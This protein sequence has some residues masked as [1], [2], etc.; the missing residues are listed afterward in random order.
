MFGKRLRAMRIKRNFTQPQLADMLN[1][2]LRTY[3]GYEGGT[4]SPSFSTLIKI[5]DI[6]DVSLD[7]LL[8]RD[9]FMKAHAIS[10]DEYL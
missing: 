5:A 7:Y 9:D 2:A 1:V 6:L 8:G 10:A 4:R 3:Q